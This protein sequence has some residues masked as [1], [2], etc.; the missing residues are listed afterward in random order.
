[1]ALLN[2]TPIS[3]ESIELGD[4]KVYNYFRLLFANVVFPWPTNDS[5]QCAWTSQARSAAVANRPRVLAFDGG[6]HEVCEARLCGINSGQPLRV[7]RD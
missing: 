1:M 4:Q 2:W 7:D 6:D 3:S 5:S